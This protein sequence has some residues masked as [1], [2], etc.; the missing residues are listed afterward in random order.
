MRKDERRQNPRTQSSGKQQGKHNKFKHRRP[1]VNPK[2]KIKLP[3]K[4]KQ[5]REWRADDIHKQQDGAAAYFERG[6]NKSR[7]QQERNNW[8]ANQK[9]TNHQ[10]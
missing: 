10:D 4:S 9:K 5:D 7:T 6:R 1:N 8:L 3:R 2:Y